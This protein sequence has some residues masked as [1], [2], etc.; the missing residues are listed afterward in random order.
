MAKIIMVFEDEVLADTS[1]QVGVRCGMQLDRDGEDPSI[2]RHNVTPAMLAGRTALRL[3][4][5][6]VNSALTPYICMDVIYKEQARQRMLAQA[7]GVAGVPGNDD[8]LGTE[9]APSEGA[10]T[11]GVAVDTVVE[12]A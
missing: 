2:A 6:N 7:A 9:V 10:T 8:A 4:E 12:G 1:D 3:F 11:N 5:L